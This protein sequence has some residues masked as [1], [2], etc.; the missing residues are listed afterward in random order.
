MEVDKAKKFRPALRMFYL[1][2]M[3]HDDQLL[4]ER[5]RLITEQHRRKGLFGVAVVG[6]GELVRRAARHQDVATKHFGSYSAGPASPLLATWRASAGKLLLSER[7]LA[8][9]TREL[10]HDLIDYPSGRI[11]FR[12]Q[13]SEDLVFKIKRLQAAHKQSLDR[14]E[15]ILELR[16]RL[17]VQRDCERAV[18]DGLMLLFGH[19][20][21]RD[22]VSIVWTEEAPLPVRSLVEQGID[23][24]LAIVTG[25]EKIRLRP[26]GYGDD[27]SVA[28]FMPAADIQTILNHQIALKRRYPKLAA[29]NI[30]DLPKDV[31]FRRAVPAVIRKIVAKM[32]EGVT[33]EEMERDK[34][35]DMSGWK[36]SI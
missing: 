34:W 12:Q 32:E 15:A 36:F 29:N 3:A 21:L 14:R 7:E 35:L 1:V 9:A 23:P 19:K 16:D 25:L 10:I 27:L 5:A 22:F 8:I 17:K 28:A 18:V 30:S 6:W 33:L 24:N 2:S 4:Q 26:P 13:E 20:V 11:V 31:Q